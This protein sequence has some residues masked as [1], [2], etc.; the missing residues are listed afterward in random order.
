MAIPE[1][2]NLTSFKALTFDCYGTLIDWEAGILEALLPEFRKTDPDLDPNRLL[3]GFA[4]IQAQQQKKRPALPYPEILS[5]TYLDLGAA[6]GN[7]PNEAR[8]RRFAESPAGWP[9]FADTVAALDYLKD[10]YTLAILSN[11]DNTSLAKTVE[12]L[13]AP[14]AI[15]VTAEETGSYKP[16]PRHFLEALARLEKMG[17]SRNEVLHVAQSKY[18]DIVPANGLGMKTVWVNRRSRKK[19]EGLS[20]PAEAEPTM[21][22]VDLAELVAF[23]RKFV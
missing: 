11:I 13:R 6:F 21:V 16:D 20:L 23:H 10:F 5:R 14:F 22:V 17:I 8:S 19:G 4:Q 18:H 7:A 12:R 2:L 9:P 1:A 3:V 15:T